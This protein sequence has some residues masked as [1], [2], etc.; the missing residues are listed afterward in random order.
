MV[1]ILSKWSNNESLNACESIK[2]QQ[3]QQKKNQER[4]VEFPCGTVG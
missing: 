1:E 3:Q 4:Y 2:K